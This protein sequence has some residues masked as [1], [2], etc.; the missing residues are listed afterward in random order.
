MEFFFDIDTDAGQELYLY[1]L[2][3]DAFELN[4]A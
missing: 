4:K 3:H 1:R 2:G